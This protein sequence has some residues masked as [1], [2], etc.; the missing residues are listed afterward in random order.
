MTPT[1]AEVSL[2][3]K[4]DSFYGKLRYAKS[5]GVDS[6]AVDREIISHYCGADYKLDSFCIEG[7]QVWDKTKVSDKDIET[8]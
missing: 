4:I 1:K 7:I 5:K 8:L 2:T 6:L 3:N